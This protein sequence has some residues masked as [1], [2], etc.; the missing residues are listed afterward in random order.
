[1]VHLIL[2][3]ATGV[4]G[5]S[6][7]HH[8]LPLTVNGGPISR[9]SVL[10]RRDVPM[11]A[12]HE[13]IKIIKTTDFGTYDSKILDELKGAQACVWALGI[14]ITSVK[15]EYVISFSNTHTFARLRKRQ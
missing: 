14:S 11:A 9:L 1:M 3:G 12:D 10:S 7:L 15:R 8:M 6:V 4:V 13:N 5:S 2:T